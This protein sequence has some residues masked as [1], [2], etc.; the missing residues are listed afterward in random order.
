MPVLRIATYLTA[1]L[2]CAGASAQDR[3]VPSLPQDRSG[4]WQGF[5]AGVNVGYGDLATNFEDLPGKD[6]SFG[7]HLGYDADL[8]TTVLGVALERIRYDVRGAGGRETRDATR[9][10]LRAGRDLGKTLIYAVAGPA[11]V[12]TPLGARSGQFAGI[13]AAHK[14]RDNL[15]VGAELLKHR[16]APSGVV[17]PKIDATTLTVTLSF[18]F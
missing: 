2:L 18:R 1:A 10:K 3:A 9:L 17:A 15:V 12:S 8:G 5:Y 7:V 13:G 14:A 16:F 4:D 6:A 11:R